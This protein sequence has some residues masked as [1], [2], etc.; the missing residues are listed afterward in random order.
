MGGPRYLVLAAEPMRHALQGGELDE[1]KIDI[2][3]I[4]AIKWDGQSET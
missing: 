3:P 4:G 2:L 1:G